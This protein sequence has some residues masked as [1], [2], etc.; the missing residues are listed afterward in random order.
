MRQSLNSYNLY[1]TAA[2]PLI[3]FIHFPYVDTLPAYCHKVDPMRDLAVRYVISVLWDN[4]D[5][6]DSL[7]ALEGDTFVCHS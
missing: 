1:D 6:A 5:H 4:G 3:E 2:E 7:E